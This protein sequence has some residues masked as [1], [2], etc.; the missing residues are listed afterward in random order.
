MIRSFPRLAQSSL[1]MMRAMILPKTGGPENFQAQNIPIRKPRAIEALVKVCSCA[2]CHRDL[3]DRRGG[4]PFIRLPAVLGHEVS[5]IVQEVGSDVQHLS[6]GDRVVSL[7]WGPCQTCPA[8]KQGRPVECQKAKETFL[9]LTQHGGYA[10]YVTTV[11]TGWLKVKTRLSSAEAAS[12]MCTYGTVW[13]AAV[14]RGQL[15]QG[16]HIVITGASGGVGSAMVR[17]ANAMGC[18]VTAVTGREDAAGYLQSLG[19]HHVIVSDPRSFHKQLRGKADMAF[20]AVGEPT[21]ES[22]LR[23]LRPGGR[24]VLIGNVTVGQVPVKLGYLILNSISIIGSD[25]CS[26][27]E[28]QATFDFLE[29]HGIRPDVTRTVGLEAVADVHEDIHKRHVQGR[30]VIQL[31]PAAWLHPL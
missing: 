10:E 18:E 14:G 29:K 13:R 19:A 25:S 17:V 5:G 15:K 22:S 28:L 4:F 7:H 11:E 3:I 24:M 1:Q 6:P 16:E 30:T 27:A 31:D 12:V 20:E 23:A 26:A 9:G 8:C 2:V 21:F